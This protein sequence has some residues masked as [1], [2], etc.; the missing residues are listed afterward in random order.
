MHNLSLTQALGLWEELV[1]AYHGKNGFGGDTAEIYMYRLMRRD[2]TAELG[3]GSLA[4]AAKRE[5]VDQASRSL[6]ALLAYFLSEHENVRLTVDGRPFGRWVAAVGNDHRV[7][8]RVI[9]GR[10]RERRT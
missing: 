6:Y 7:H 2:P 4:S 3:A 1:E 8:V 10:R 5:Q 9:H